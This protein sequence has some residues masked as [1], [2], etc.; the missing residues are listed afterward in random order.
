MKVCIYFESYYVGGLDTFTINL[1]NN[2]PIQEP[3]C[4]MCNKSHT[5]ANYLKD[6]ITN[7][8]CLVEIH[9]M[10][11]ISH[12]GARF[13]NVIIRKSIE[14]ITRFI[15]TP[16]YIFYGYKF[17]K[18]NRFTHLHVIN[19]GYPACLS[20]RCIAISWW[21]YTKKKSIH[22]FHNY[23]VKSNFIHAISDGIIDRLLIKSTSYFV[24][25]SKDCAYSL[26]IRKPFKKVET[27][28]HIYNGI[29]DERLMPSFNIREELSLPNDSKILIMLATYEE[30]KGHKHIIDIFGEVVKKLKNVNLIF[31]GYGT[32][33]EMNKVVDYANEKGLGKKIICLGFKSN[34]MEYLAQADIVVIGSQSF[35]SFGLTAV[36]AMK[37][38]KPVVSTNTGGLKEV[39]KDGEGGYTFDICDKTGMSNCIIDLF[40][41]NKEMK[42]QGELGRKRYLSLYTASR[43]S[44]EYRALL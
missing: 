28:R 35:E 29:S 40:L 4:L 31:M 23:A 25:V 22:N 44:S 30:R 38:E 15:L 14:L 36:E 5:G 1:I 13:E 34:A 39:I 12:W 3:L 16:C 24:S 32:C 6:N 27:I 9:N 18:L 21:L 41:D 17:L 20:S 8:N 11:M 7:T 37:Y 2:W 26:S 43:M 33:I 42:R 19:G 10:P